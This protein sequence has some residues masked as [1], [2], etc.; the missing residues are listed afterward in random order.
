[1]V[2]LTQVLRFAVRDEAGR[3]APV[4]D[5]AIALLD[6]D[7]PPV[8]HIYFEENG[9]KRRVAWDLV[10]DLDIMGRS[11][12]VND[13][14]SAETADAEHDVLLKRD[15]LDSLILDLLGRRTTRVCDLLLDA[16]DGQLRVKA[17][18]GGIR[19]MLRR[20]LRGSWPAADQESMFD[21][22]YVEFLRGDPDAVRNGA[23]YRMRIGRLPAGEIARLSDYIPYLHAAELLKLL[24][25]EKAADVLEA[26]AIER[27]VQII[28]ELD[29]TEAIN[30]LCLMAPDLATDLAGRLE[31]SMMRRYLSKMPPECRE[32]IVE[33]LRYSEDSVGGAMTNDIIALPAGL[34]RAAAKKSVEGVL[35]NVRFTSLIFIIDNENDRRLCGMVSLR[36]LLAADET[37]SLEELMDPYVQT[38]SPYDDAKNA[39]YRIVGSQLPAMAVVN[40]TGRLLG[41]MTI[42]AALPRLLPPTSSIQRVKIYS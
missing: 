40:T 21:W 41:A 25:D 34:D 19:C 1:M 22:K 26:T 28:D 16:N 42:E 7:Y 23:G 30:L 3:H 8:T 24:P 6:D 15:I 13:I 11:L 18:D 31:L 17:A 33:L 35:E 14:N 36:D 5:L 38:L 12:R 39:A 37:T 9:N 29:E 32:P 10:T 27:Q 2:M 4:S 20:I